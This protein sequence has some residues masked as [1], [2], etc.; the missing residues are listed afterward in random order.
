MQRRVEAAP[1]TVDVAMPDKTMKRRL[2]R[3]RLAGAALAACLAVAFAM[4]F[5]APTVANAQ[6]IVIANGSPITELDIQQRYF[7][8]GEAIAHLNYLWRA[9]RL[10]R[11]VA[12]DGAIR[13][14]LPAN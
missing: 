5:A 7:A 11:R 10:D 12:A 6:V 2:L 14:A 4:A 9:Q 8:M 1:E 3:Q 13:F